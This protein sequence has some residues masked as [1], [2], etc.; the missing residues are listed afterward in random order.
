MLCYREIVERGGFI[1]FSNLELIEELYQRWQ[2]DPASVDPT[3]AYFF[4]GVQFASDLPQALPAR[5]DSADLRVF[6]LVTA[7]R[8]YGHLYAK[9]NPIATSDP[10]FPSELKIENFGFTTADLEALFPTL[11]FLSK[12]TAPLKELITALQKVYCNRIGIEYMD[13]GN[14]EMEK[15]IQAR[16]EPDF[17]K[18]FPTEEKLQM[19]QELNSAEGFEI[20]LHTKYVGQK[21]FSLEGAETLIPMMH[22]IL[23]TGAVSDLVLG[24]A[25]RGRLNVLANIL[26]KSYEYIFSEFEDH[27]DPQVTE[28]SGDVKYHKGF[29]ATYIAPGDKKVQIILSANPSHLESVDPVVEGGARA[30]QEQKKAKELQKDILPLLIHG[31]SAVSGQG[32]VYETMGFCRLNGYSTRGTLHIVINNQI[33]FTTLPKD[34]RSTR[35]C[36]DIAKGFGAPVFH[37]NAEDPEGCVAVAKLALELRQKFGCDVFIDLNGYRKYGHNEGDEPVFTQPL[38]YQLIRSKK[39]IRE[40]YSE[41]LVH[42]STADEK[43]ILAIEEQYKT[44]LSEA[45]V[46]VKSKTP[47]PRTTPFPK[48]EHL[49]EL[50]KSL[51]TQVEASTLKRLVEAMCR[52]PDGFNLNP[53]IQKL[54]KER[55]EMIQGDPTKPTLDWAMG[56][57]LA[58]AT[59]CDAGTHVRL[60]GQ[61]VRRGTF[62]HRHGV[63]VDQVT[64][65]RYFPLSHLKP[66]QAPCDLFNSSL[67]EMGVLGFEFGYSVIYPNS[68]VLWEAQFGDFSNG[69]QIIT[70]Q[71]ISSSESKWGLTCNLT[72]LLPHGYEGQGPEHSSAR[73]ERFLQLCSGENMVAANC[74]TPAQLFHLLRRQGLRTLKKP[75][76]VF[77]PKA[78]LRHPLC[79]SPLN[80]FTS[81]SFEEILD[82]PTPAAK[83]RKLIL[84]TGKIYYDLVNE[85]SQRGAA[86]A[87]IVRIEQ[88]YPLHE[89]KLKAIF[90]KYSTMEECVWVQEE[91]QNMGAWS[92]LRLKFEQL[93][94]GRAPLKYIGRESS[95]SPSA[96]SFA[97]HKLQYET[98]MKNLFTRTN[99]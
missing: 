1:N 28:A 56:E 5:R 80:D 12:E 90:D 36:T 32:V 51:P 58:Y 52:I 45:L 2:A 10:A 9:V 66:G 8:T 55:L 57:L 62:S 93:L 94:G 71:Y 97:L 13:V 73:M 18:P 74:S 17:P 40:I 22:A 69:A 26:G 89:A 54:I 39:S 33:G 81:K 24:M 92:F 49:S 46:K 30:L 43:T 31:D 75:L 77:T 48:T 87:T 60:S 16:I 37:V 95:A 98:V 27:Y 91:P 63:W 29:A 42:E 41:K 96:G 70:D 6:N 20:F 4:E 61:D 82:D 65:E 34:S 88:L 85:R 19:L 38:E 79:R 35:Y 86:D 50:L 7:Y 67:S 83:T 25:H 44:S 23:R 99:G 84:C 78:L 14:T 53:K 3:W 64:S 11:G 76:I 47:P 15:W 72:L 21:R 68:L 59:L